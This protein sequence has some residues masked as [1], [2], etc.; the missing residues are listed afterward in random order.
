[1]N[2]LKNILKDTILES[3]DGYNTPAAIAKEKSI[4]KKKVKPEDKKKYDWTKFN[5]LCK[6]KNRQTKIV[7]FQL[8]KEIPENFFWSKANL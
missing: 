4:G 1:M 6:T 7:G 2:K 8:Q 5:L 3:K